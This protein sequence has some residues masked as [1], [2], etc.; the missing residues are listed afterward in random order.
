MA[1]VKDSVPIIKIKSQENTTSK[2]EVFSVVE[3]MPEFPG[4]INEI[5]KFF[6]KNIIYP[7]SAKEKNIEGECY[8]S[9]IID[10]IGKVTNSKIIKGILNC[11]ECDIEAIRVVNS[12]PKW[13]P[14]KH[15]G[16]L[17]FVPIN[18]PILFTLDKKIKK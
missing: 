12:M 3:D 13:K 14:G 1:Q 2:T 16:K 15:N 18:I 8:V 10:T 4:G 17:V 9:F 6:S 11:L 5:I 7:K